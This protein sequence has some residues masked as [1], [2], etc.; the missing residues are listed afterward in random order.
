[1]QVKYSYF[2]FLFNV[3][4][5]INSEPIKYAKRFWLIA[6]VNHHFL[7]IVNRVTYA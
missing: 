1:M 5:I 2:S 6:T 3:A 4:P 7:V